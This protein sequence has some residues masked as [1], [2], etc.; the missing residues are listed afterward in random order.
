MNLLLA[1]VLLVQDKSTEE[2]LKLSPP[3]EKPVR[4]RWQ[5]NSAMAHQSYPPIRSRKS[6]AK[7]RGRGD[8]K[9]PG[10]D[11]FEL[12]GQDN[13]NTGHATDRFPL[14]AYVEQRPM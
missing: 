2:T 11:F 1:A 10:E 14:H 6:G 12:R 4:I 7:A 13:Q 3:K 5:E 9:Q 8:S